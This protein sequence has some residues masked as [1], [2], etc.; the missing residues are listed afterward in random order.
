MSP[1]TVG[2]EL[3]ASGAL[4]R[5]RRE[6][7]EA[8]AACRCC[9]RRCGIDRLA[10]EL[11]YCQTGETAVVGS[12]NAHHGEEPPISGHDGSG[13]VFFSRCTMRCLFCQN[14]PL[15]QMGVGRPMSPPELA[16]AFLS[17][18]ARGCHNINL[19]TA[20]HVILPVLRALELAYPRGFSLPIV[21]NSSGYQSPEGLALLAGVVD[22]YL[23]DIKYRLPELAREYSDAADYPEHNGPALREMHRQAGLLETDDRGIARRGVLVRHLVLPGQLEN[24]RLCLEFLA[25]EISPD[26]FVSF[27]GQYF[28]A[29]RAME[30]PRL[31]R[32]LRREEYIAALALL[33]E[34]G[35]ENGWQQEAEDL[36]EGEGE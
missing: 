31:S 16:D 14:Y 27:M 19:V 3:F 5:R 26:V 7:E 11:G 21:W 2:Q 4:P 36:P 22:I 25:R 8:Y 32:R 13:T 28:P 6:A 17:L 30:H 18:Q 9:P 35:L 34:F 15:I 20:D 29:Y 33:E 1:Q 24:T 10:G 12:F 23:P